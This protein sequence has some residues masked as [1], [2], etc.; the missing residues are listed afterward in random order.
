MIRGR[1]HVS[2]GD[3]VHGPFVSALSAETSAIHMAKQDFRFGV[4]ATVTVVG[5]KPEVVYDNQQ[6]PH[7]EF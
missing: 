4:D 7:Q 5:E 2:H 3:E 6:P 1:W